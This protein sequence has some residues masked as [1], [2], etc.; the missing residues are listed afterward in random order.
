MRQGAG[1]GT[2]V[3]KHIEEAGVGKL[4]PV[5]GRWQF[6]LHAA[7]RQAGPWQVCPGCRTYLRQRTAIRRAVSAIRSCSLGTPWFLYQR[8][9]VHAPVVGP[10]RRFPGRV[11]LCGPRLRAALAFVPVFD[12]TGVVLLAYSA[13]VQNN[14]SWLHAWP[15]HR[16][17]AQARPRF[18]M[19]TGP[20]LVTKQLLNGPWQLSLRTAI[21]RAVP[22]IRSI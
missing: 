8:C 5:C 7:G 18:P 6:C 4:R 20:V 17:S 14:M 22:R 1:R 12:S 21:L 10:I 16:T 9:Q 2:R 19:Q 13:L 3:G 15:R 11:R